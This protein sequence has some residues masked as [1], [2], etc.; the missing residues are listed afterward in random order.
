MGF[1]SMREAKPKL[2]SK[3]F[4]ELKNRLQKATDGIERPS[5][6]LE[7]VEQ[8]FNVIQYE[9][10]HDQESDEDGEGQKFKFNELEIRD[11][12]LEFMQSLM[13]GYTKYLVKT[14]NF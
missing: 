5:P 13:L 11:A 4:K 6:L 3:E 14:W 1:I 10:S 2:P 12:F 7:Q 8:A 9:E